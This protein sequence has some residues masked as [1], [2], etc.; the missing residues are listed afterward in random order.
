MAN[1]FTVKDLQLWPIRQVYSTANCLQVRL[2]AK[3]IYREDVGIIIYQ[4]CE[5]T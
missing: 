5:L 4:K 2:F 3:Y 1:L